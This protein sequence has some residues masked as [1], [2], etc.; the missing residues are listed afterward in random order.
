MNTA[1]V[2]CR[3]L[4]YA[5]GETLTG[6]HFGPGSGPI[7]DHVDCDGSEETLLDCVQTGWDEH[8]CSHFEDATVRCGTS[9]YCIFFKI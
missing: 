1:Q 5:G 2:V 4:G 9:Y 3:Q 7:L 8:D 6:G